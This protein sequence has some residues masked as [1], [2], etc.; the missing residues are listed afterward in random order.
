MALRKEK[1]VSLKE[2]KE[3]SQKI[4]QG[5][6]PAKRVF[7]TLRSAGQPELF[8]TRNSIWCLASKQISPLN[9]VF[10]PGH[11]D[12]AGVRQRHQATHKASEL[13]LFC[14]SVPWR[15]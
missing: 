3:Y 8:F 6:L 4:M 10:E 14:E 12:G 5:T 9:K 2:Q 11:E 1:C 15:H 13:P 7:I